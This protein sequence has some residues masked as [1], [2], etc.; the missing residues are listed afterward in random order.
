MKTARFP[1]LAT[2]FALFMAVLAFSLASC[3]DKKEDPAA[4]EARREARRE[5]HKEEIKK[6]L[7]AEARQK[8]EAELQALKA[9]RAKIEAAL[10]SA[11][12]S[13]ERAND[14]AD[15]DRIDA[16]TAANTASAAQSKIFAGKEKKLTKENAY[17]QN[18]KA[19]K[20]SDAAAAALSEFSALN[21]RLNEIKRQEAAAEKKLQSL[22]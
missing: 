4:R 22:Q 3:E 8:I 17:L 21:S 14:R 1:S 7:Q 6:E 5:A 9:E 13:L 16:Q 2:I 10:P 12:R 19:V 20:S 18:Q 11:K 15:R